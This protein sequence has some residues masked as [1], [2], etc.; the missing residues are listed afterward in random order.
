MDAVD[1]FIETG[2]DEL[3]EIVRRLVGF[4]TT[5]VDLSPG[6]AH[7]TNDEAALQAYVSE[8]LAGL[9][10]QVD[11]WEPD[12]AEFREHPMMPP[13]HHWRG[14]PLTVGTLP[15]AGGGRSL[16]VNGHID[17]VDAGEESRWT[18]PPFAAEV[19]AGRI[20]GRGAV[21]MKGGV[22]AALF[23]LKALTACEIR[24]AGDVFTDSYTSAAFSDKNVGMDKTVTVTGISL[25]GADAG[26]Y[27]F[28]TLA[29]TSA[30]RS[31]RVD[32]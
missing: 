13:W 3:V 26:N 17:V 20:Y 23:A 29:S 19:R 31:N 27:T 8:E 15:G 1:D 22:G 10:A 12:P 11:Q 21:D 6:S 32:A 24:L 9:G 2:R 16:I 7:T 30:A 4:D 25:S 28:N 18:S 5:S 14:R